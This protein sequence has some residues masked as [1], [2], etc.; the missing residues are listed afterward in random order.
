MSTKVNRHK[1][2][3]ELV[4]KKKISTQNKLTEELRKLGFKVTQSTISRDIVELKLNKIR[5][6]SE[7]SIY[8]L[9]EESKL[10]RLFRD[11]VISIER[12][13]NLIVIKTA[14]GSAQGIASAIDSYGVNGILGTVAGDDTILAIAKTENIG[15]RVVAK[16]K[17]F[18]FH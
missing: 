13:G 6:N 9:E 15:S 7:V 17:K 4:Q 12:A 14:P 16:L 2:I 8:A 1:A 11:L 10:G 5:I 18:E 3:R